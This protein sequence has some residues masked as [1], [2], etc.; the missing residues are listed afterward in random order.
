MCVQPP[1]GLLLGPIFMARKMRPARVYIHVLAAWQR[2]I[3]LDADVDDSAR[4]FAPGQ[5]SIHSR[6]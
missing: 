2:L 3:A 4:A 1:Q 6:Q 5:S